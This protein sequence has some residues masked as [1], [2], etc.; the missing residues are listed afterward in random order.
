MGVSSVNEYSK[1]RATHRL[2]RQIKIFIEYSQCVPERSNFDRVI[3]EGCLCFVYVD[4]IWRGLSRDSRRGPRVTRWFGYV[5][6]RRA[7]VVYLTYK[8]TLISAA[9]A[10]VKNVHKCSW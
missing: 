10:S 8:R 9:R 1:L 5:C 3:P 6:V 2:R 4:A 7:S